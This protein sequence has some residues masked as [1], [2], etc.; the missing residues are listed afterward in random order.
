MR[1]L[2]RNFSGRASGTSGRRRKRAKMF[3]IR[4][5]GRGGERAGLLSGGN[6]ED[7]LGSAAD[8]GQQDRQRLVSER[9]KIEVEILMERTSTCFENMF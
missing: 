3:A 7:F 8:A 5:G 9:Q 1:L 4:K 6:A 2:W